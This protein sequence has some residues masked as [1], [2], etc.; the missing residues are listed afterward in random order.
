M[1]DRKC[2]YIPWKISKTIPKIIIID[3]DFDIIEPDENIEPEESA[4]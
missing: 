2:I 1:R 4:K 3:S